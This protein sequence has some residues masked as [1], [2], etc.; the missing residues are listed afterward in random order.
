MSAIKNGEISLSF[1]F[2]KIA[3]GPGTCF[4]SP[5]LI[6]VSRIEHLRDACHAALVFDQILFWQF[7]GLKGNKHKCNFH[8][9]AMPIMMSQILKSVD[10]RKTQRSRY[11][12]NE[13]FF[14]K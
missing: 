3:K 11:I 7:L 2:M 6:P 1:L 13:T 14:F 4:K 10:F 12:E 9:V 8:Y 5:A